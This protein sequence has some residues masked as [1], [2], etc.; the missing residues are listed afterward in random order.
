MPF[1]SDCR[2]CVEHSRRAMLI[3]QRTAR[4]KRPK[5]S[6]ETLLEGL[7]HYTTFGRGHDGHKEKPFSVAS[8]ALG[9]SV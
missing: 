7:D 6:P 5:E 4:K 1:L 3:R 9:K 2:Y 8:K